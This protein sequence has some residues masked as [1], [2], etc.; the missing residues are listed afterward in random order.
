MKVFVL[1][2]SASKEFEML[3]TNVPYVTEN[4]DS[5]KAFKKI[6]KYMP[7]QI[8]VNFDLYPQY[9]LQSIRSVRWLDQ[10]SQ[11]PVFFVDGNIG[12]KIQSRELGICIN[13]M[14][15]APM[16]RTFDNVVLS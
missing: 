7:D 2:F 14:D 16:L 3:F 8:F 15:V 5:G 10:T 1:D 4:L 6:S 9:C 13:Q 11:I 12:S